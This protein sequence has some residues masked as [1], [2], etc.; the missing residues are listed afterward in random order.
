MD[1]IAAVG[2]TNP[3]KLAAAQAVIPRAFP[4]CQVVGV[5]VPSGVPDQPIGSTQTAAGARRRAQNALAAVPGARLG[6]GLEGGMEPDGHLINCCAVA[7]ATGEV[8]LAWGVR[9]PLPPAVAARVLAGE[10]LGHVMDQ[11]AGRTGSKAGLGAV[12][13]LTRGLFT[14]AEMWQGPLACALAPLLSA[15]LYA[16][17]PARPLPPSR[18]FTVATFVVHQGRV[19]LLFHKKLQMWLPP[20]GHI[21]PGE[22]PDQA[23]VREV[24][25]ETGL[26]VE[27]VSAPAFTG[28][29]GPLPLAR[30]EGI[31]LEDIAPGHQHIDLI[32]FA[33]PA[34]GTDPV[35]N[36]AEAGAVGWFGPADFDRLGLTAEVR[37]WCLRALAA[38][39]EPAPPA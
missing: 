34:A 33:R 32:Y 39:T 24:Q 20:G 25:E 28:V 1:L 27:L 35:P 19:L 17:P 36:A 37:A 30:P 23:A 7:T 3:A 18:D 22:L 29:P 2:S 38:V 15:D 9:F 5:P 31:Q 11:M 8:H 13:I 26:Q 4:G 14:R 21:E 16:L 10:E 6:I 12:G